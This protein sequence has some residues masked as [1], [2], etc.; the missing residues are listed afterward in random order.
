VLL[1]LIAG[2][3]L[4]FGAL[5][6]I[7]SLLGVN[8]PP[9]GTEASITVDRISDSPGSVSVSGRAYQANEIVRLTA[10]GSDVGTTTSDES[11]SF[12][13]QVD[14]GEGSSGTIQAVGMTS[15]RRST[16][17]YD[18]TGAD[19]TESPPDASPG[20]ATPTSDTS[21]D[22]P[23]SAAAAIVK[24][25]PPNTILFYST[26]SD[27]PEQA[28][29]KDNELYAIDPETKD[30]TQLTSNAFE[31]TFPTWSPD[32]TRIA[33]TRGDA[34]S[35]YIVRRDADGRD[36]RITHADGDFDVFP[37]WSVRD[38]I[39]YVHQ[40]A[41]DQ[42]SIRMVQA[43]GDNDQEVFSGRYVRAPAW[44]PDGSML[45]FMI[46]QDGKTYDLVEIHIDDATRTLRNL[47]VTPNTELNPS[48]STDLRTL[49]YVTEFDGAGIPRREIAKVDIYTHASTRLTTNDVQDGNPVWS[50]DGN[51]I[52]FYRASNDNGFH[53]W[54]MNQDGSGQE[55]LMPDRPGRNLDPN[56]R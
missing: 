53:I 27:D 31:D 11:G 7:G 10:D 55:D 22:E 16:A 1:A 19:R 51:R 52:A 48:L 45:L 38:W 5:A 50:A 20:E 49:A 42:S 43:N 17:D 40:T 34:K 30:I 56:W 33:Y 6:V 41:P 4:V 46:S 2:G 36:T 47:Y 44:S 35:R 3:V 54:T 18:T 39:A 25:P 37:A 32:H 26:Y 21:T 14:V 12:E 24:I 9:T 29:Q 23:S 8:A 15:G 13:T 28:D